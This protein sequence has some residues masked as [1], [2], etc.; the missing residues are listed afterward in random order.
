MVQTKKCIKNVREQETKVDKEKLPTELVW[1]STGLVAGVH[2]IKE[3]RDLDSAFS[4]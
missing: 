4:H 1:V 2:L 3:A